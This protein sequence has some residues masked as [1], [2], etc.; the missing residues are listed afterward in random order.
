MSTLAAD[1]PRA[2][3]I[4]CLNDVAVSASI[5]LAVPSSPEPV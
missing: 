2:E 3:V 1:A 5:E 4:A